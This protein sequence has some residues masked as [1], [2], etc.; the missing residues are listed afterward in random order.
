MAMTLA[1]DLRPRLL[2]PADPS[3]LMLGEDPRLLGNWSV[4][5]KTGALDATKA[6][7][8]IQSLSWVRLTTAECSPIS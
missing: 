3:R 1:A 5:I 4:P 8:G 7:L 6:T 2:D